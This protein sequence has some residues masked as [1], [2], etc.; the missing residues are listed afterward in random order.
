MARAVVERPTERGTPLGETHDRTPPELWVVV[1]LLALAGSVMVYQ[2]VPLI[3]EVLGFTFR[4]FEALG[5]FY[6]VYLVELALLGGVL[7]ALANR[8]YRREESARLTAAVLCGAVGSSYLLQAHRA[9][10][11]NSVMILA[12]IT[13]G[14]LALAPSIRAW[15][16]ASASST[17]P[18]RAS[19]T[20]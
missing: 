2:T 12:L 5:L 1:G 6:V 18:S 15:F 14:V 9:D 3:P 20:R 11:E 17:P 13:G 10:T 19:S 16:T 7:L 8:L 4:P